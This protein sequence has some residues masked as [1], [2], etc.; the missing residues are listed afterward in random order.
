[1]AIISLYPHPEKNCPT[2]SPSHW[3]KDL[4]ARSAHLLVRIGGMVAGPPQAIGLRL[5]ASNCETARNQTT[6]KL[7]LCA[8]CTIHE[9]AASRTRAGFRPRFLGSW[10]GVNPSRLEIRIFHSG[11]GSVFRFVRPETRII[12]CSTAACTCSSEH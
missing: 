3:K 6:T 4:I 9:F 1:M 5:A 8:I 12:F 7:A 10:G 2:S 11:S